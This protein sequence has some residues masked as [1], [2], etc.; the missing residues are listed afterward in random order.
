[1]IINQINENFWCIPEAQRSNFT[2]DT[3]SF[4]NESRT[5]RIQRIKA[6]NGKELALKLGDNFRELKDGDIL[7]REGSN[8]TIARIEPT[9]VIIIKPHSILQAL[10]VAHGLGN[11]HLQAQFFGTDSSFGAE[12]MVVRQDHTVE[13]FLDHAGV[14]YTNDSCVMPEAFRHAEHTH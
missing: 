4:D 11:R 12:V 13:H 2:I 9:D 6:S 5:K 14:A 1:M 7:A 10:S 3:V 8:L